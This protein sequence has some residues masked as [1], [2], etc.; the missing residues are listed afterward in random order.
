MKTITCKHTHRTRNSGSPANAPTGRVRKKLEFS[1]LKQRKTRRNRAV[2]TW[3]SKMNCV[4]FGFAL[5]RS[6]IGLKIS[7][8][9]IS[10]SELKPKPIA[11][12]SRTF[13]RASCQLHVFAS[14]FDWFTLLS[15]SFV[16][17]RSNN[18][19][20]G[21]TTL[22]WKLLY[23][24]HDKILFYLLMFIQI[25]QITEK[26]SLLLNHS[27][28]NIVHDD[29]TIIYRS[30]FSLRTK[31][32]FTGHF[33]GNAENINVTDLQ[34][35]RSSLSYGICLRWLLTV[36]WQTEYFGNSLH[37]GGV[38]YWNSCR[39]KEGKEKGK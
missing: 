23:D 11:T 18:F 19:G 24:Q 13:S 1:L 29:L 38:K 21:F 17:G 34:Y 26:R 2:F 3:V 27:D 5:L 33:R 20:F 22:N 37:Q 15:V 6:V 4:C 31:Y 36:S 35:N 28:M 16:I 32:Y 10:Q 8:H 7:R 9:F 30:A 25:S 12:R 39:L 14:S